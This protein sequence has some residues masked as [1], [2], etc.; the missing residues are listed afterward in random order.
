MTGRGMITVG[1]FDGLSGD[2]GHINM[3]S[4]IRKLH[5]PVGMT[6]SFPWYTI[7]RTGLTTAAVPT[8]GNA[9]RGGGGV[10]G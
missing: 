8:V 10:S 5:V 2:W 4:H 7:P 6:T 3:L 1:L 9:G